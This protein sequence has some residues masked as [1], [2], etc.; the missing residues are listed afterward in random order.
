MAIPSV[1]IQPSAAH[2]AT[3]IFLHGLGDSGHGWTSVMRL[4]SRA[5]PF[6]KFILPHAPNSPVTING[7]MRMPS[8][9]DIRSLAENDS[10]P[11]DEAGMM[12]TR[13]LIDELVL[14]EIGTGL[15]AARVVVGG[16]SQGGAMS[17]LFGLTGAHRVGAT[18]ALSAYLPLRSKFTQLLL[19]DRKEMPVFM[20]HGTADHVVH[21]KWGKH[22]AEHLQSLG[23]T[24]LTFKSYEN[25][26]HSFNDFELEDL[27]AFLHSVFDSKSFPTKETL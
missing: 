16:F 23:C 13:R 20:G 25:L 27:K 2:T 9:Y 19:Q 8:W 18:I 14:E 12:A 4:L 11:D 7:G 5:F 26:D 10:V 6:I 3:L 24:K 1:V 17:L 21:H 15:P 22:S